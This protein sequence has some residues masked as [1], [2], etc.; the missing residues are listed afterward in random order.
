MSDWLER[1][2]ARGLA[3]VAAPEALRIRLGLAPA[4]RRKL[5]RV[6]L[7]VAAAVTLIIGASVAAGRT[8][9]LDLRSAAGVD[10]VRESA[11]GVRLARCDGGAGLPVRVNAGKA[12]VLLAHASSEMPAHTSAGATEAGCHLCHSL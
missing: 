6:A 1:E 12:T 5:P 10:V 3:P 8:A 2:L 11:E 4:R 7:S 9:A